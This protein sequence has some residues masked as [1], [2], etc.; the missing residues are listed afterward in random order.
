MSPKVYEK[1]GILI[2]RNYLRTIISNNQRGSQRMS[3]EHGFHGD[4]TNY[5]T[6][7]D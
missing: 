6:S 1:K 3:G 7:K 5:F 2:E 4:L